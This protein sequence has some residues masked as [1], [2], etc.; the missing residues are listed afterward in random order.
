LF[1]TS[2]FFGACHKRFT[3]AKDAVSQQE[4]V[5]LQEDVAEHAI[6]EH[7][8]RTNAVQGQLRGMELQENM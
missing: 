5:I 1:S 3:A 6:L 8:C 7:F 2:G 4:S